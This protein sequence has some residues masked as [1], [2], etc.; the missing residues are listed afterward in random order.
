MPEHW[1][2][3][4]REIDRAAAPPSAAADA[5]GR[6]AAM[7]AATQELNAHFKRAHPASPSA[8]P[9]AKRRAPERTRLAVCESPFLLADTLN[10]A[11]AAGFRLV[12]ASGPFRHRWQAARYSA[13]WGSG[14]RGLLPRCEDGF[15]LSARYAKRFYVDPACVGEVV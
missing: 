8:A 4:L 12:A 15:A 14:R 10:T 11:G 6:H 13:L 9:E 1:V 7:A 3:L 2:A 5:A